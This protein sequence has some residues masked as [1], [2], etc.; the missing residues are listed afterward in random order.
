LQASKQVM[1]QAR[2]WPF[3]EA[4]DRQAEFLDPVFASEDAKEGAAA[5]VEKRPP[6]WKGR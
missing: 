2:R 5:F 4:F 6:V 3:E 1:V